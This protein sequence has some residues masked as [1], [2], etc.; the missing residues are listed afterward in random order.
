MSIQGSYGSQYICTFMA[1]LP[2]I[3]DDFPR[4]LRMYIA[5][6]VNGKSFLNLLSSYDW[7]CPPREDRPRVESF[8]EYTPT[9]GN[10]FSISTVTMDS[11]STWPPE[12]SLSCSAGIKASNAWYIWFVF[13]FMKNQFLSN[14]AIQYVVRCLQ[15][16]VRI[17]MR[18]ICPYSRQWNQCHHRDFVQGGVNFQ[19]HYQ[20]IFC[21]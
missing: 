17:S 2:A 21:L 7:W 11:P 8:H 4:V 18:T 15:M 6:I 20:S 14:D 16:M 13:L 3:L 12:F 9:H 1:I 10:L 19:V 5:N